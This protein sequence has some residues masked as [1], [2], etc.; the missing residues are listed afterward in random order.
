MN[1][2]YTVP[3]SCKGI[4]VE[5]GKVWLRLNERESWELPGGKLEAGQQPE[6]VVAREM[7]EELGLEVIVGA[8]V[9]NYLHTVPTS[10]DEKDGVFIVIYY[11]AFVKRTGQLEDEGEAGSAE[12]KAFAK[13]QIDDLPM[14]V[15]YKKAIRAALKGKRL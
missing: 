13:D 10:R 9:A 14:P 11:C 2:T 6:A 3:I 7:L 1:P 15:F 8:P 12:F 4:V 5:D